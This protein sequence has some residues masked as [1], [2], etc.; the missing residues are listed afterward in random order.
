MKDINP[1]RQFRMPAVDIAAKR[2]FTPLKRLKLS[3]SGCLFFLT[4]V[5]L[6]F[7][8][9]LFA[10][11]IEAW[12]ILLFAAIIVLAGNYGFKHR[13]SPPCAWIA[14]LGMGALIGSI[15]LLIG[16]Q[17]SWLYWLMFFFLILFGL[18]R[19]NR[20]SG[21][22]FDFHTLSSNAIHQGCL[23]GFFRPFNDEYSTYTQNLIVPILKGYGY[24][25][26]VSDKNLENTPFDGLFG[27]EYKNLP[28]LAGGYKFSNE[29]WQEKV[30][31]IINKIDIA[32]VDISSPNV[33]LFWELSKCYEKV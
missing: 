26:Y 27:K 6:L 23:I 22:W 16:I 29:E 24:V 21:S 18:I 30:N 15:M 28:G 2:N 12:I 7:T 3:Q 8:F 19:V 33:N 25:Y 20:Y 32:V 5:A 17:S 9:I 14:A 1:G 10:D 31:G 13:V 4:A 11:I